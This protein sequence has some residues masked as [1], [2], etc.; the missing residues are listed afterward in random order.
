MYAEAATVVERALQ[1]STEECAVHAAGKAQHC[2]R[3]LWEASLNSVDSYVVPTY[4]STFMDIGCPN[5]ERKAAGRSGRP[6]KDASTR[7]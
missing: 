3:F 1:H 4:A 2:P 7:I 5:H 6:G